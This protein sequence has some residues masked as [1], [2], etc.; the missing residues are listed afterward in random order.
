MIADTIATRPYRAG[1]LRY[2]RFLFVLRFPSSS[3]FFP[4]FLLFVLVCYVTWA[5]IVHSAFARRFPQS[6]VVSSTYCLSLIYPLSSH[7]LRRVCLFSSFSPCR[8]CAIH[9]LSCSL[10]VCTA[11]GLQPPIDTL[12]RRTNYQQQQKKQK[13]SNRNKGQ[14]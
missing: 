14:I 8:H 12:K 10:S 11:S 9:L 1:Y 7:H 5:A 3:F 4:V 6:V 2:D 13:A